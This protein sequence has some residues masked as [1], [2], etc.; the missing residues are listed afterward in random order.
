MMGLWLNDMPSVTSTLRRCGDSM[1]GKEEL[2][3]RL[4]Q[5]RR[6][7]AE[8]LDPLTKDRIRSLIAVLEQQIAAVETRDTHSP[9]N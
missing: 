7:V 9:P 6:L 5:S 4:E 1:T 8:A 2:Y 3:R